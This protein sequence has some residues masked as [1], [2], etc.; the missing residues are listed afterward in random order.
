MTE[1]VDELRRLVEN[2][3]MVA[4][5]REANKLGRYQPYIKQM[6]FH[7]HGAFK[8][9]RLLKAGNQLGKTYCGAAEA[10]YHLTGLYPHWWTGK[11][12]DR[13]IRMWVGG[14]SASVVRDTTQKLLLGDLASDR[15]NLGTGLIP[16]SCFPKKPSWSRGVDSGVDNVSVQHVSGKFSTLI[17]KSYEQGRVKWQGDSIDLL[18]CDEEPP[19]DVY[20]EGLARLTATNGISYITFTPLKGMSTV[21]KKFISPD[22]HDEGRHERIVV[23]MTMDDA[24]HMTPEMRRKALGRYPEHERATRANGDIMMGEGRIFNI[25]DSVIS[26]E[27]FQIP[28]Y[29]KHLIGLDLGHGQGEKAHPTSAVWGALDPD[30]DVLYVYGAYRR[31]GANIPTHAAAL[32]AK[33]IIPIA[34]PADAHQ[35]DKATGKTVA[36]HYKE[37][38][39]SML[40]SHAV[41]EDGSLSV[42]AGVD[43]IINRATTGRLKVFGHL[44]EFFEEWRN[45]H[46]DDHK[47]V[48]ID[49]DLISALRYLIMMLKYAKTVQNSGSWRK[50]GSQLKVASGM[51]FDI[52]TGR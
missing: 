11:R 19:D 6:E 48:P 29:W 36:K 35:G 1:R 4:L 15:E 27:A 18:W 22:P 42:W 17:F 40:Q 49:D 51:D 5:E 12:W 28:S 37:A 30:Q 23:N 2:L 24:A 26:V 8:S 32:K 20:S 9:E 14:E 16:K 41:W 38:G 33:G 47:I 10:A 31:Q 52:F 34:W 13:P 39:C 3:D 7:G 43:E 44:S 21:V 50:K 25:A 45:Y 46:M